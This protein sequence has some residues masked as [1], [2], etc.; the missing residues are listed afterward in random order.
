MILFRQIDTR[1]PCLWEDERQPPGRWHGEG[2]GPAHYFADT[3]DGAWAEYLRHEE[4]YD[5]EQLKEVARHI[6][7][8]DVGNIS[9]SAVDLHLNILTGGPDTYE[10]CRERAR[11]MRGEGVR[12]LSA[13]SAALKDGM[14]G[15]LDVF[16]G[17]HVARRS[18]LVIVIFGQPVMTPIGW[19]AADAAY[20]AAYV[21]DRMRRLGESGPD[22]PLVG[23]TV[24]PPPEGSRDR[25]VRLRRERSIRRII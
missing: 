24:D 14:A 5:P 11:A 9:P 20:P 4:I 8:V 6:W 3:P 22:S 13:P 7:A 23:R 18:G 16:G 19:I 1:Y 2:E 25:M 17:S 21:L 10:R 15:G 12:C